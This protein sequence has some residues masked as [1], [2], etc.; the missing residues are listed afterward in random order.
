[1]GAPAARASELAFHWT[2]MGHEVTVLED[3][4]DWFEASGDGT[5]LV[6]SDHDDLAV[7]PGDHKADADSTDRGTEADG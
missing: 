7:I 1:M 6:I 5:R 2:R 3:G 4:V